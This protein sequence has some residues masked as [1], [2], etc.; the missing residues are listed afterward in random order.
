M[1][2][3]RIV[4]G[5]AGNPNSGKTTVFNNFTGSR[6][7]VGNYP[8]V[9]V[10]KKEGVLTYR[11]YEITLVDLPGI[12]SLTAYSI[13]E[14]ITRNFIIENKPD[15][16]VDIIDSSNLERNLYLAVQ[17]IELGAPLVLAFNMSDLAAR[18]GLYI[19]REKLSGLL[20]CPIVFTVAVKNKGL[21]DVLNAA[22]EL[23]ESGSKA[24]NS[25][26]G[27]GEDIQ[28]EL[29]KMET[30]LIKDKNLVQKY[31]RKWLA[32][33]L[34]ES[35]AEVVKKIKSTPFSEEILAQNEKSSQRLTAVYADTPEAIIADY[36][37]GFING[38]CSETVQRPPQDRRS[39]SD[40]IDRIVINRFL[41]FPIFICSIWLVFKFTFVLGG[42]LVN[43]IRIFQDRLASLVMEFVPSVGGV[44]SL[45]AEGIIS[46][47]GSVIAFVPTI[48]F[49]FL[50]M[51][52]LEYSGY[53]AR[54][55]F[56]MDSLMHKI[57]LH[58]RSF[59][60]MLLGFG[61]NVPAIMA[62]RTIEDR[63]DRLVTI[64]INPFMSCGARL[65]VYALFIGAF[66][67]LGSAG[68][69][70]FSIYLLGILAAVIMAKIFRKY[71]FKGEAAPFVM[72][73]PPYRLPT[74][75]GLLLHAAEKVWVYFRKAGTIIFAASLIVWF[76]GN[77]PKNSTPSPG[78]NINRSMRFESTSRT[79]EESYL[80]KVGKVITPV[81]NPLGFG[82]WR[83]A[84][85]LMGGFVAK[86][87]II[88]TLG[89]LNSGGEDGASGLLSRKLQD[90]VRFDGS[91]VFTPLSAY[92]FMV[93]VLLYVPCIAV[94]A[95]ARRETGSWG[96][97][98][99]MVGYTTALAWI[100]SFSIYQAGRLLGLG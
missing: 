11:D 46:G 13:D 71:L 74:L 73:L 33:K 99:F 41:G 64:L 82:D 34:L 25:C 35:D 42:P 19:D 96:W 88:S 21:T 12:Y 9:T 29:E 61:C 43:L 65:P 58:G 60:P 85:G 15:V 30:V 47:V 91:K 36:R 94:V 97:A 32:I 10:E 4:I 92:S 93:F 63:Q 95:V 68:N 48:F 2:K 89:T 52:F 62:A 78:H 53:L 14:I 83:V 7:R 87:I 22:I 56:V 76:L 81:F 79:M 24:D 31:P 50:A 55:A 3:K 67:P 98:L 57:G 44:N 18:E 6:Q 8:G 51:A 45:V 26:I 84:V 16:V 20:G 17:L 28:K 75:R 23:F 40:R 80:G 70:L 38:A 49:L 90:M 59:I 72:E 77:Y 69:V 5:L 100:V 1:P 86:E 27:Y 54:V 39:L 66:F 37:Y